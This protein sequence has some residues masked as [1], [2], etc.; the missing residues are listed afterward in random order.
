MNQPPTREEERVVRDLVATFTDTERDARAHRRLEA[1]AEREGLL[2]VAYR[3]V[4][5][6]LGPLLLAATSAGLVRV[7]FD[8]EGHDAVLAR[9]A[10]ELSPRILRAPRR[11]ED[12]AR[13]MGEYFSGKRRAFELSLDLRLAHGFRRDVLVHLGEIPYGI[14][15]SYASVARAAGR[16]TA[17]R[18]AASACSHNPLPVI[19]PCHRVVRSD[20]SIGQYLAG[21]AAK[22]ALL[23]ME[24]EARGWREPR[25]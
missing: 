23:E 7:A 18:A 4:D 24:S 22:R 14:T 25:D 8:L 5:S 10:S 15:E 20:G 6:P 16:P 21:S 2:D 12:A 1:A 13:Q 3:T 19:V 11:L 17:V 9:L